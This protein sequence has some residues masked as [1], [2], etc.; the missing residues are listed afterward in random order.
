MRKLIGIVIICIG[1][2]VMFAPKIIGMTENKHLKA[3]KDLFFLTTERRKIVV[4]EETGQKEMGYEEYQSSVDGGKYL[5]ETAPSDASS[6]IISY[7]DIPKIGISYPIRY[8]TG[9]EILS[10]G[11]GVL[12]NTHLP[13]GGESKNSVLVGHRGYRG[14]HAF[15][16]NL[17]SLAISDEVFIKDKDEVRAYE[18]KEI[19]IVSPEDLSHIVVEK[20]KDKITLVTCH[21]YMINSER[22]I[23]ILERDN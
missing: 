18:V 20:G 15:F 14:I 21:P 13:I 6:D 22:L 1:I 3:E 2:G 9:K 19:H 5:M 23:L 10:K 12:E 17:D 8:G 4:E 7:I 11:I 16:R